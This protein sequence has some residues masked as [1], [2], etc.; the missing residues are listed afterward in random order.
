MD[1]EIVYNKYKYK[2]EIENIQYNKNIILN[3]KIKYNNIILDKQL[4]YYNPFA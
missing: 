2:N 4:K 1:Y 3:E